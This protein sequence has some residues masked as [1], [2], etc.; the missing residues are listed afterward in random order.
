[1]RGQARRALR[2]FNF[3]KVEKA[4][5]TRLGESGSRGKKRKKLTLPAFK[6]GYMKSFD[7]RITLMPL[8]IPTK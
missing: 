3:S 8:L 1:M 5:G 2:D 7:P 6:F 4:L